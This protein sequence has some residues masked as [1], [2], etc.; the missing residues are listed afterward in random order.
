MEAELDHL[1]G[2]RAEHDG[3]GQEEGELRGYRAA[4]AEQ[5]AAEDRRAGAARARHEREDL[6]DADDQGRLVVEATKVRDDRA[7]VL[8]VV[9]N[10]DEHDAVENQRRRDDR[11]RHEVLLHVLIEEQADDCGRDAGHDDL[12]PKLHRVVLLLTR[13]PR[14]ERIELLKAQHDDGHDGAELDDDEEHVHERLADI[15]LDELIDKNHMA[16]TRYWQPLRKTLHNA[17]DDGLE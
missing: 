2:T 4:R 16:R 10:D 7:A 14:R 13:L 12:H 17:E 8:V 15:E 9:L 3:D 5:Q 11:R 6:E 1:Q